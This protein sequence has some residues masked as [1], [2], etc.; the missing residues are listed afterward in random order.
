MYL[1]CT[2]QCIYRLRYKRMHIVRTKSIH[3]VHTLEMTYNI[4]SL[5]KNKKYDRNKKQKMGKYFKATIFFLF[6]RENNDTK[7]GKSVK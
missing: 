1:L 4:S 5:L 6:C 2:L 7:R 3:D